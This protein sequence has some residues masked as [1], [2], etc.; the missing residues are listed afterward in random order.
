MIKKSIFKDG[1]NKNLTHPMKRKGIS[2]IVLVITIVVIIILAAAVILSMGKNNP[3]ESARQAQKAQDFANMQTELDMYISTKYAN[4]LG[5]FDK[6]K[7]NADKTTEPSITEVLKSIDGTK[8]EDT[9]TIV[10]GKISQKIN[11]GE[12]VY[13]VNATV[14]GK[15]FAYNNPVVPVGFKT[16]DTEK[17]KWT[18]KDGIIEDWDEGLVVLDENDNEYI[19]IPVYNLNETDKIEYSKREGGEGDS[20]RVVTID[21]VSDDS[22]PAGIISENDQIIKYGGFYVARYE[23]GLP[24]SETTEELMKTKSFSPETNNKVDLGKAQSKENKIV[25]N[26]ITYENA[27]IIAENVVSNEYVQSG[28][29]T[30]TQWDTMCK[31][32]EKDGIE[33]FSNNYDWGNVKNKINYI[34]N[35]VYYVLPNSEFSIKYNKGNYEKSV[36]G[37]L[38]LPTGIFATR[39]ENGAITE[40]STPKNLYDVYGNIMEW[41]TEEVKNDKNDIVKEDN[42]VVRGGA[43]HGTSNVTYRNGGYIKNAADLYTGFRFVLFVK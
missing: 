43:L 25:W 24:D 12:E 36:I 27:K 15:A 17:A 41:T 23:A 40:N 35:D 13:G 38:L 42:S 29:L 16:L 37:K 1:A 11:S 39:I 10:N 32:I 26:N 31:F 3:V 9:I 21:E 33:V 8:Y 4:T 28:L 14:T 30:G 22:L 34:V 18:V 6:N 20:E 7:F 19:W 2:L 5:E